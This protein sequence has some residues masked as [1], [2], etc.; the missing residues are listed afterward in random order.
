MDSFEVGAGVLDTTN[1]YGG[2]NDFTFSAF[3]TR[4]SS[5]D[6]F[7]IVARAKNTLVAGFSLYVRPDGHIQ[8]TAYG[9]WE[10]GADENANG[11]DK[12]RIGIAGF[13]TPTCV[14]SVSTFDSSYNSGWTRE[15]VSSTSLQTNTRTHVAFVRRS[16]SFE[17]YIDGVH[18]CTAPFTG[19]W[20]DAAGIVSPDNLVLGAHYSGTSATAGLF[21]G[22][23]EKARF[24]SWTS[25]SCKER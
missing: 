3:V 13:T 19:T 7:T 5:S 9:K 12:G 24:F 18:S 10:N 16:Q 17:L 14:S 1:W 4:A 8:L 21:Q 23:I 2:L 11:Y 20:E 25:I 22:K 15:L 6:Q